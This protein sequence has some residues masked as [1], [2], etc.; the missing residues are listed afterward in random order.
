MIEDSDGKT[1]SILFGL[2]LFHAI[3]ISR[4]G[5]GTMGYNMKYP[6][7]IGDLRDSATCLTNYME[8]SSGGKVPWEDLK[9]I[10][11]EIMYGGHIIN[12]FDRLMAMTYLQ[13]YLK[14][15]LLEETEL[16]PFAE[17]EGY[18]FKTC[19]PTSYDKYLEHIEENMGVDTPVAFGL[20]TNAEIDFRTTKSK[21]LFHTLAEL[22]HDEGGGGGGDDEGKG[23]ARTPMDI[24]KDAMNDISERFGERFID[25]YDVEQNLEEVGPYQNVFL[26]EIEAMNKVTR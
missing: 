13:W 3:L 22:A 18:S 17:G 16:Y 23:E 8:N 20:H 24:A 14:D 9:Y 5:F 15:D 11:G 10:F 4:K 7:A 6:F 26:Q 1:R 21:A 25:S 12:D 2:C 19:M